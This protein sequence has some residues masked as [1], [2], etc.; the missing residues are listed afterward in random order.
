MRT[1]VSVKYAARAAHHSLLDESRAELGSQH[2]FAGAPEAAAAIDAFLEQLDACCTSERAFTLELDD[3]A[4]GPCAAA[5]GIGLRS[6]NVSHL[7]N[8]AGNSYVESPDGNVQADSALRVRTPSARLRFSA[9]VWLLVSPVLLL[10]KYLWHT[11]CVCVCVCVCVRVRA[12]AQQLDCFSQPRGCR[13]TGTSAAR[14][15]RVLSASPQETRRQQSR[16][17][18]S[19]CVFFCS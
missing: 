3:P 10:H 5:L 16:R 1:E 4:G 9:S 7:S 19:W 15:S 12:C 8:A 13:C 14:S 6:A 18:R 17:P 11:L 2:V